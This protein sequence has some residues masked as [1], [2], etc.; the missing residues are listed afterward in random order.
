MSH[1]L[2]ELSLEVDMMY[3]SSAVN[4]AHVTVL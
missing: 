4:L 2:T 3:D 1:I